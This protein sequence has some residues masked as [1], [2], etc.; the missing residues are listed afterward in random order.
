MFDIVRSS[1]HITA[2]HLN[3]QYS[4]N[5]SHYLIPPHTAVSG[6]CVHSPERTL[7][8]SSLLSPPPHSPSLSHSHSPC[9]WLER[10]A[11]PP[12]DTSLPSPHYPSLSSTRQQGRS[13]PRRRSSER[14]GA[15]STQVTAVDRSLTTWLTKCTLAGLRRGQSDRGDDSYRLQG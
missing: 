2:P 15:G 3:H 11:G 5:Y 6:W 8:L 1:K 9:T 12:S 13:A 10:A 4:G 14:E 7:R